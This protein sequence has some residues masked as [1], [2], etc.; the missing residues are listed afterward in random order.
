MEID[1]G[2]ELISSPFYRLVIDLPGVAAA[3]DSLV[4]RILVVGLFRREREREGGD[5]I[6][7]VRV[8]DLQH[9]FQHRG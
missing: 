7:R 6:G 2:R 3:F 5:L 9:R 1:G 4:G 8:G